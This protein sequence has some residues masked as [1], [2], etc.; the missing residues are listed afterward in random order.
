M[1]VSYSMVAS[2]SHTWSV[3]VQL[4]TVAS[5]TE[6]WA[7][8]DT[9]T[10]TIIGN[11][12]ATV[13]QITIEGYFR[14]YVGSVSYV[15]LSVPIFVTLSSA[16]AIRY[17]VPETT[18]SSSTRSNALVIG[19]VVGSAVVLALLAGAIIFIVRKRTESSLSSE[20]SSAELTTIGSDVRVSTVDEEGSDELDD[21]S[22]HGD[23][24]LTQIPDL[25]TGIT[26]S[27]GPDIYI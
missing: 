8:L 15:P 25:D 4:V 13:T 11:T 27:D 10:L 3:T 23:H 6:T 17:M 1:S 26:L 19:S 20:L 22:D 2:Y 12:S 7:A 18:V 24:D 14:T 16:V 5:E 9:V 21:S